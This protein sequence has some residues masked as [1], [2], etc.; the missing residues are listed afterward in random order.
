MTNKTNFKRFSLTELIILIVLLVILVALLIPTFFKSEEVAKLTSCSSN[1]KQCSQ[2]LLLYAFSNDNMICTYGNK[3]SGW[4]EQPGVPENIGFKI[5]PA[6]RSALTE[7]PI[8]I[9]PD[10]WI[11]SSRAQSYG[12]A[13]FIPRQDYEEAECDTVVN[14]PTNA[15]QVVY[16]NK[17][18]SASSYVL[19]ADTAYTPR[20]GGDITPGVQCMLFARRNI[21]TTSYFPRAICLRHLGEANLAMADGHVTTTADRQ[22]IMMESKISAFTDATG[23]SVVATD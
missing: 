6:K 19:L 3:W 2:G 4:F 1:M 20:E 7:R 16:L 15:G 14:F 8:T 12:V 17:I 11:P 23:R 10:V 13:W 9:C 22:K 21:G 5:S 18:P